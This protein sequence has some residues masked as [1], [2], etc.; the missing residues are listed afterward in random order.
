M[1]GWTAE[2]F[3]AHIGG[4]FDAIEAAAR[5]ASSTAEIGPLRH[6][7][8]KEWLGPKPGAFLPREVFERLRDRLGAVSDVLTERFVA[9]KAAGRDDPGGGRIVI[10]R[11]GPT[12]AGFFRARHTSNAD[13]PWDASLAREAIRSA[14]ARLGVALPRPLRDL[15]ALQDGGHTDFHL[16]STTASPAHEFAGSADAAI[17]AYDVWLSVLPGHDIVP[18]ARLETLGAI[19]DGIDFGDPDEA[20]RARLPEVDRLI[21]ISN[22]GSDIWLCL[23]YR[24]GRR[25]PRVVLFDDTGRDR[26]GG[27]DFAYEAPD[28]A[29]FF[30]AL[31]RHAVTIENGLR[32]RGVRVGGTIR[33]RR[34]ARHGRLAVVPRAV[35][36][37]RGGDGALS[38]GRAGAGGDRR[39]PVDVARDGDPRR[40]RP[41]HPG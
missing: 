40:D 39:V 28:F 41:A 8:D 6:R 16:A 30:S 2:R 18:L 14:E 29:R 22:H 7:L 19:S 35:R 4:V 3:E 17:A 20:W 10:E 33:D 5:G 1:T 23:D 38:R 9:L 26:P 32:V 37:R 21:P 24:E 31:R 13:R 11:E 34:R 25:E 27:S 15:Y 12:L 36:A